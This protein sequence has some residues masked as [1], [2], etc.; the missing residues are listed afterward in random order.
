MPV[1]EV[2][3]DLLATC[4]RSFTPWVFKYRTINKLFSAFAWIRKVSG[5]RPNL[6][7]QAFKRTYANALYDTA[8]DDL[9]SVQELAHHASIQTTQ[10]AYLRRRRLD[11]KR[12]VLSAS[13]QEIAS[14]INLQGLT[15]A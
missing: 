2:L 13:R 12:A 14:V 11:T 15:K 3:D 5:I 10:A 9:L 7:I 6:T 8:G 4:P 1:D